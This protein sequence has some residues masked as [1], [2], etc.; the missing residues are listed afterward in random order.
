M[1]TVK[2][3]PDYSRELLHIRKTFDSLYSLRRG[4]HGT[5]IL[6]YPSLL[7]YIAVTTIPGFSLAIAPAREIRR[8]G[9]HS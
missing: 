2:C 4:W 8:S 3:V 7:I 5:T 6:G 1:C 9:V